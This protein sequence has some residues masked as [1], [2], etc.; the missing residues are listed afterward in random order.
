MA[1]RNRRTRRALAAIA[2]ACAASAVQAAGGHHAVDD[3]T[4]QGRAECEQETWSSR[5]SDGERLLHAGLSCRVGP[6]ELGAAGEHSRNDDGPATIWQA[7]VK[8]ARSV[9]D[10][11]SIGFDLLPAWAAHQRPRYLGTRFAALATWSTN[12]ALAVHVNVGRDFLRDGR[13]L[14]NGGVA[15]EWMPVPRWS[16]LLE[17]YLDSETHFL[18]SGARWSAGRQWAVDVSYAQR[19]SGAIPSFWTVGLTIELG[20]N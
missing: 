3:A 14:A 19:L 16:L 17:R 4:I 20:G 7:E 5:A 6:V 2:L 12:P 11:M 9:S 1:G 18:R 10:S 13:D 8:W 15:V